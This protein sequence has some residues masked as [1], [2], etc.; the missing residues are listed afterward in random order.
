MD[1][2]GITLLEIVISVGIFVMLTFS[3]AYIL[4]T[5]L[6]SNAIVWDQLQIQNEG[7]KVIQQVVDEVRRA[8]SSSIGSY[9]I[10]TSSANDLVFYANIDDDELR[11]RVRFWLDGTVLKRS[12]VK[13]SGADL[14]Y[15][16][17]NA[18]VVELAHNLTNA[19]DGEAVFEYYDGDY[20]G[21]GSGLTQPVSTTAVRAVRVQLNFERAPDKSPEPLRVEAFTSIRNLKTN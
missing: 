13:P 21:S 11:E 2:R 4:I 10:A 9:A 8:E 15:N 20:T 3:I 17:A 5:T 14:A 12:T 16:N 1:R 7:R 18:F 19:A 6:K